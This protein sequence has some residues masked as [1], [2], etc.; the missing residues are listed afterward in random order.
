MAHEEI[1]A[2]TGLRVD[3]GASSRKGVT[4]WRIRDRLLDEFRKACAK[5]RGFFGKR[6]VA[7][8]QALADRDKLF[9]KLATV[10]LSGALYQ[11]EFATEDAAWKAIEG[12]L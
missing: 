2:L 7:A 9:P 12:L 3:H 6:L 10:K 5:D 1:T 8:S 11:R 4:P